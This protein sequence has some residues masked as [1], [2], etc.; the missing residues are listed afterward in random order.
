M[1]HVQN[2]EL[3]PAER[4]AESANRE[5]EQHVLVRREDR[6]ALGADDE[7]GALLE[8]DAREQSAVWFQHA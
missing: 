3:V 7:V 5:V 8:R 6:V 4:L 1:N 2:L